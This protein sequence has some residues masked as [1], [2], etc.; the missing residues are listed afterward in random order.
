MLLLKPCVLDWICG[1]GRWVGGCQPKYNRAEKEWALEI[2]NSKNKV[3]SS[4]LGELIV[5]NILELNGEKVWRPKTI[6]GCRPDWE[7]EESIYEVKTRNWTTTGT[8]GEKILGVPYKY[9]N[10]PQLYNKPLKIVLVGYQEYEA[11]VKF[12]IFNPT[13]QRQAQIDL[14]KTQ[15]IEFLKCSELLDNRIKVLP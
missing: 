2:L 13:K 4:S 9:A 12:N 5:K 15:G 10:V 1:R 7:T 11:T 8:V 3:W 6:E 14:W